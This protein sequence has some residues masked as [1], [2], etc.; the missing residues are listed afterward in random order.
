MNK[1][2]FTLTEV[3]V[4]VAIVGILAVVVVQIYG[5]YMT[6]MRR[7]EAITTLERVALYEERAFAERNQFESLPD[8]I[9]N[10]GLT[11]PNADV[12]RNYQIAITSA[13]YTT[14]YVASASPINRQAGDPLVFA[15]DNNGNRGTLN[16]AAVSANQTMWNSLH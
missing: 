6:R 16:G 12:T 5:G 11:D 8:L 10:R 9:A 13:D 15:I 3:M 7:R 4:T 2:G 14:G 1:K